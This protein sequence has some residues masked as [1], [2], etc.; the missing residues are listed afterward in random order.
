MSQ[1]I[2]VRNAGRVEQ[3]VIV[4]GRRFALEGHQIRVFEPEVAN[5]FLERCAPH[6]VREGGINVVEEDRPRGDLVWLYNTTGNPDAPAQVEALDQEKGVSVRRMIDNP[7]RN[8]IPVSRELN[9]SEVATVYKGEQTSRRNPPRKITVYPWTRKGFERPEAEWM[10]NR[11]ANRSPLYRSLSRSRA[12][13]GFEPNDSWE[14]NSLISY[15]QLID[16][17]CKLTPS[18]E[19]IAVRF[20]K[21]D[22]GLKDEL[23]FEIAGKSLETVIAEASQLMMRRLFFRIADPAFR[24]PTK[25]E[26]DEFT[27]PEAAH[28]DTAGDTPSAPAVSVPTHTPDGRR[29]TIR[30]RRELAQKAREQA[31]P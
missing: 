5:A 1:P 17:K 23:G 4:N 7:V 26:F 28:S 24:L 18:E 20:D 29:L 10:L 6:V 27:R 15:A 21:K 2:A 13:G 9:G 14:L 22:P 25:R 8:G 30:E 19:E 31:S 3:Y 11:E 12:P 16:P